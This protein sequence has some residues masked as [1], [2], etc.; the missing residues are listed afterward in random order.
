MDARLR[1]VVNVLDLRPVVRFTGFRRDI[2][3]IL[4]GSDLMVLPSHWE[5]FGLVLLEAME[6]GIPVVGTRVGAIPEVVA[7]DE[8]GLIVPPRDADALATALVRLLENPARAREMGQA[9]RSRLE[10]VFPMERAIR[11]HE[12]LYAELL[13]RRRRP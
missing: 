3:R 7:E 8:T 10:N 5:G 13:A 6:A 2:R 12:D 11:A 4:E 9:G 1:E